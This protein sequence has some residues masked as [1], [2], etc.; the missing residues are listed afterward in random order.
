MKKEYFLIMLTFLLLCCAKEKNEPQA[1][2]P[3]NP[4]TLL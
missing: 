1:S 3:K 4:A 2:L